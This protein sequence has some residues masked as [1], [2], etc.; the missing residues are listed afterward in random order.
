MRSRRPIAVLKL[1]RHFSSAR[2]VDTLSDPD[3]DTPTTVAK[4]GRYLFAV[5]SRFLPNP[6][7]Q[8]RYS[9]V[10]VDTR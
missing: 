8:D 10:R 7:P 6:T 3:L 1:G 2:L 9:I 5:N 4:Q